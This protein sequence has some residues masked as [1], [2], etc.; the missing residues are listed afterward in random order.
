MNLCRTASGI[1]AVGCLLA[2]TPAA[3]H[4]A[5]TENDNK[6][7]YDYSLVAFDGKEAPL[8]TFKGKVLLVVNLA[9]QSIF[10][11]QIPQLEELQ[12][13]YK[14]QG[15]VVVG[16][17]CND[18]GAQEPG[19]DAEIQKRYTNEF[20]LSF[21]YL[22]GRPFGVRIRPRC[23]DFSPRTRKGER[24]VKFTGATRNLS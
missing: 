4:S 15:L 17:P 18:F 11:E 9:S 20:H 3:G 24:E 14:D 23:M 10:K 13:K 12:K 6:T 7:L 5:A 22:P 8:S 21:P 1:L 19:T 2:L 16:V